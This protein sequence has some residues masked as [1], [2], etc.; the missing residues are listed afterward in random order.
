[1]HVTDVMAYLAQGSECKKETA[2]IALLHT[3]AELAH[4]SLTYPAH[5]PPF[6]R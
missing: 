6:S 2:S 4:S 1:M 5:S 3:S